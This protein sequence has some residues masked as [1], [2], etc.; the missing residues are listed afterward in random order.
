MNELITDFLHTRQINSF[1]KLR[2]LL[3]MAQHPH[4]MGTCQQWAEW[5]HLGDT[6][7]LEK[8][9]GELRQAGLISCRQEGCTLVNEAEIKSH[10]KALGRIFNDPLARQTLLRHV[11]RPKLKRC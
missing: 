5:L 8:L 9:L 7:L 10:L 11:S 3:F 6:S 1:Q 4:R 2:I